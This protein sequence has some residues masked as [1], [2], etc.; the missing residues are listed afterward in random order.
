VY[1][2]LPNGKFQLVA[3]EYGVPIDPQHPDVPPAGFTGAA[4][5]WD[6][7]TLNLGLWTLHAWVWKTNPNGV[8]A[9]TNPNVP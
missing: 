1:N 3:V 9:M 2:K 7:N 4:D 5:E 8:F 6:F